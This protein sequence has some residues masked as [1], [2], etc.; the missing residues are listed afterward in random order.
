MVLLWLWCRPVTVA[1]IRPLAL[2]PPYASGEALEK[3]KKDKKKN[4]YHSTNPISKTE[5]NLNVH[6]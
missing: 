2:Q 1:L 3:A 6:L 4:V 5:N